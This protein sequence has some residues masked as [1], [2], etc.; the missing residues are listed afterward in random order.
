[1]NTSPTTFEFVTITSSSPN[2]TAEGRSLVKKHVMRDIGLER[3][4][5]MAKIQPKAQNCS[6]PPTVSACHPAF[7][8]K[9]SERKYSKQEEAFDNAQ[10]FESLYIP[11]GL[12]YGTKITGWGRLD[13][14]NSFPV[15]ASPEV[16]FLVHHSQSRTNTPPLFHLFD[17]V[18]SMMIAMLHSSFSENIGF[19]CLFKIKVPFTVFLLLQLIIA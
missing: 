4:K 14:F 5:F 15:Q 2:L 7:S 6:V 13:P 8:R 16:E 19:P 11:A 12:L 18:Q 17:S 10:N 1:M 9:L 3:R